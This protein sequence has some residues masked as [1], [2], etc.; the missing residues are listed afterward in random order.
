MQQKT[1]NFSSLPAAA[2]ETKLSPPAQADLL[3]R[4]FIA[5]LAV[6][7]EKEW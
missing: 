7:D 1:A 2:V 6:H 4:C 5:F 3:S